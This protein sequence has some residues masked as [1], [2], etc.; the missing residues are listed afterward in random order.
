MMTLGIYYYYLPML[1]LVL[2][3]EAA[4]RGEAK[5]TNYVSNMCARLFA[6]YIFAFCATSIVPT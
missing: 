3:R 5:R 1:E 2:S 6:N 4:A